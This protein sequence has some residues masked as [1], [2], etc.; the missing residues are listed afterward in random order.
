MQDFERKYCLNRFYTLLTLILQQQLLG[1][2]K[3]KQSK[4]AFY[5]DIMVAKKISVDED[6]DPAKVMY[7]DMLLQAL[8]AQI[9]ELCEIQNSLVTDLWLQPF[10]DGKDSIARILGL[11]SDEFRS[12]LFIIWKYLRMTQWIVTEENG[13]FISCKRTDR[14]AASLGLKLL[15]RSYGANA[16]YYRIHKDDNSST[17]REQ[18]YGPKPIDHSL[19]SNPFSYRLNDDEYKNLEMEIQSST[20]TNLTKG[21][22]A[23]APVLKIKDV[24]N[25]HPN[26][27]LVVRRISDNVLGTTLLNG[28]TRHWFYM[29]KTK[30]I[31][32]RFVHNFV[33][34]WGPKTVS[35]FLSVLTTGNEDGLLPDMSF[36]AANL[37]IR[38]LT[39]FTRDRDVAKVR[40]QVSIPKFLAMQQLC[41]ISDRGANMLRR[42]LK[43]NIGYTLL[44]GKNEVSDFIK[45]QDIPTLEFKTFT[46]NGE[47]I[48]C[49][50]V[51]PIAAL[52]HLIK[53]Y[54]SMHE[55]VLGGSK[56]F[57]VN[58]QI[59]KGGGSTKLIMILAS[60]CVEGQH[61][62]TPLGSYEGPDDYAH[63]SKFTMLFTEEMNEISK[64][65][66]FHIKKRRAMGLCAP[67]YRAVSNQ[68]PQQQ[69]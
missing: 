66:L 63:L 10:T 46:V 68:R 19:P 60:P 21:L 45:A 22:L 16:T 58:F 61:F 33:N 38:V 27:F 67:P 65:G 41:H 23:L 59:D 3:K 32:A 20:R 15:V 69:Q 35:A 29:R 12:I 7:A 6:F 57:A 31:G 11:S 9:K 56:K 8:R 13:T 24:D 34:N 55:C 54:Q 40:L 50:Y 42:F 52:N 64:C 26:S 62:P 2:P 4:F 18:T 53:K 25:K 39:K 1:F 43:R 47:V 44:P 49:D 37:M 48:D 28:K 51:S 17:F 14:L 36:K 5:I 30:L